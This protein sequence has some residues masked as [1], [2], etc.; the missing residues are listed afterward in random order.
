M[1]KKG[2]DEATLIELEVKREL[3]RLVKARAEKLDREQAIEAKKEAA[4]Q[5]WDAELF[6]RQREYEQADAELLEAVDALTLAEEGYQ[7]AKFERD[8]AKAR[9]E[10]A[11]RRM[12]EAHKRMV[13]EEGDPRRSTEPPDRAGDP[14]VK[15]LTQVRAGRLGNY[16]ET[17]P[18]SFT[19]AGGGRREGQAEGLPIGWWREGGRRGDHSSRSR[20]VIGREVLPQSDSAK[21]PGRFGSRCVAQPDFGP[22]Q[23]GA[24]AERSNVACM[25]GGFGP[26]VANIEVRSRVKISRPVTVSAGSKSPI[27]PAPPP[28][29]SSLPAVAER[30]MPAPQSR[31]PKPPMAVCGLEAVAAPH[32]RETV[33]SMRPI[34]VVGRGE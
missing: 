6:A 11:E 1:L 30:S 24:R 4:R 18:R 2:G 22:C 23:E 19:G 25:S 29:Y 34:G 21:A 15:E 9:V 13:D 12:M 14:G 27:A 32:G 8:H 20:A 5:K 33:S 28:W 31:P 16:V 3:R 17:V 10:E 7:R 26:R